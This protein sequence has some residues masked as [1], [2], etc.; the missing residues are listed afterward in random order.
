MRKDINTRLI[1]RATAK[2]L[3]AI[4]V[5]LLALAALPALPALAAGCTATSSG[6]WSTAGI[7]SCGHV[8]TAADDVMIGNGLTVAMD[9]A[10]ATVNSLTILDGNANIALNISGTNVLTVTGDVTVEN[11]NNNTNKILNVAAGTLNIGGNL[12]FNQGTQ[13][14]VTRVTIGTGTLTLGGNMTLN[15][16][17]TGTAAQV[18]F[19]GAGTLNVAGIYPA[20]TTLTTV[21]DRKSVV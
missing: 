11:T 17:G 5:V 7:W 16:S 14:R 8:P 3:A 13:N 15:A 10:S 18:V 20:G 1:G 19:S 2:W 4:M 6:N 21:A 12:N 9:V